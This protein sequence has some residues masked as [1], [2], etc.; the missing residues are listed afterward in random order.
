MPQRKRRLLNRLDQIREK[1]IGDVRDDESQHLAGPGSQI[2]RIDIRRVTYLF[3]GG[4]NALFRFFTDKARF[5]DDVGNRG[6]SCH[7]SNSD[8][9]HGESSTL[10][11][12]ILGA[13]TTYVR[14]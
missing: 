9:T 3:N 2:S 13:L 8:G 12:S 4:E 5:V 10:L 14:L 6:Q 11:G 1:R 7:F